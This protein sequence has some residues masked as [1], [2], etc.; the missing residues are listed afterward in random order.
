MG[1]YKKW[2]RFR[3]AIAFSGKTGKVTGFADSDLGIDKRDVGIGELF[4]LPT[5]RVHGNVVVENARP[6]DVPP[7]GLVVRLAVRGRPGFGRESLTGPVDAGEFAIEGALAGEFGLRLVG[8]PKGY[9]I[10]EATQ[11]GRDVLKDG[12][13]TGRGEIRI[14]LRADAKTTSQIG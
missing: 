1:I 14:V 2:W 11:Q 13:Q 5:V 3:L 12:V 9:Y 8:L 7:P 6:E 4:P 10:R